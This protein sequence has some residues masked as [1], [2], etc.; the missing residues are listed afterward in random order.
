MKTRILIG[1]STAGSAVAFIGNPNAAL[2]SRTT[3]ATANIPQ[4]LWASTLEDV[5][6][7]KAEADD[8]ENKE[9]SFGDR[10]ASSGMASAAAVATAAVN[11]AVSMKPLDAPDVEK[12]Y[13]ALDKTQQEL[14]EEGLPI[15]YDKDLIEQYWSKERGALNQRWGYFVGKAVPFL[16]KMTTLFIRDG[17]ITDKEIPALSRQARVDLQDLGPTFIKAGQMMSVRP[18]V[19]PQ[20]TLDELTKLQDSVVPFDTEIA[21]QQIEK[22]LGGPLGQFFTSIS[23]E[24]V[25]AASLAQVYLATLNDGKNTKVAVKV[26]RP[27]VLGTVSKDLYVLR[28]AAEVFQGLVDRFAPQQRTNYVALLNE[29]AI[30]FYTELDFSN[31]ARNQQ[32]LRDMMREKNIKGVT[33][34]KVYHELCTRRLLVS[35]WMDGK[36]LSDATT[37]DI[38]RVT[39]FAQEA[40]LTQLLEVGFF[41]G[42]PHPGNLLLL[43]EPTEEGYELALI[44]CGLM[45]SINDVDRDNMISAVI[46]LANKDYASLVD[47]FIKLKILPE[48]SNRAA[49]IP[50]MDKALSPYVKGGGAKK[51]EEELKKLYGMEDSDMQSTVGGFQAMTQDALTVLNDIPFSIPPYFAILG[52]AIVTLEGIAL[53]GNPNYGIILESYPFIARKLLRE[54]RPEIQSA[55]QEVLY[56]GEE[57][58]SGLK[59]TR[60]LALLNNAA[61]AV[62]TRDGAAFVDLDAVPENGL[63]FKE[64]LKFVLSDDSESLRNLLEPEVDSIVDILSRQI[65]RKAISDAVVA[66]TPP[67]PPALPFLGDIFPS[68]PKLDEIRFPFLLPGSAGLRDP[69]LSVLTIKELTDAVAPKLTQADEIFALG[70]SDAATEFFGPDVG[71]FVKG[72]SVFSAKTGELVIAALRSGAIGETDALSPEVVNSVIEAVSN[73]LSLVR[74][75]NSETSGIEKELTAAIDNLDENESARLKDI[76]AQ[77]TERSIARA[78]ERLSVVDRVLGS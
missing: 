13:V 72:E 16:T 31:E 66:L 23:E 71:A 47:D 21:V 41:H 19:L 8:D 54:D 17:K 4:P 34:P 43:N 46:H 48:D 22:E 49:I 39:P 62:A 76:V 52:R 64:G 33:V 27:S 20:P 77:I 75:A 18:D 30:G 15:V 32:T 35:E 68:A 60:L 3:S 50:L 57:G 74:G 78:I 73:T 61:G 29:W 63:G 67:R 5:D 53:T 10:M 69:S 12:S 51:Y 25:A 55:L 42:D 45:A 70:L 9:M 26:Q 11:A 24:P 59:L 14:D 7:K 36:K 2:L 38:A 58:D 37:E 56:S 1:L 44:D 65:F 40:F 28:R 6:T